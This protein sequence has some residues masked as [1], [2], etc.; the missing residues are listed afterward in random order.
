MGY[1]Q[2]CSSSRA[3]SIWNV[4]F[5]QRRILQKKFSVGRTVALA[6]AMREQIIVRSTL[7]SVNQTLQEVSTNEL[8][9]MKGL[10]KILNFVNIGNKI[11]NKYAFATLSLAM[12]DHATRIRQAVEEVRDV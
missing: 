1:F 11:E 2:F 8:T 7:K 4:G 12:N 6:E 9:L 3:L 10:H 5:G